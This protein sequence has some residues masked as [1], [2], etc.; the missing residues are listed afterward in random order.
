MNALCSSCRYARVGDNWLTLSANWGL[1]LCMFFGLLQRAGV[2]QSD[3]YSDYNFGLVIVSCEVFVPLLALVMIV[4]EIATYLW[5]RFITKHLQDAMV[6]KALLDVSAMRKLSMLSLRS[7]GVRD[8]E[9]VKRAAKEFYETLNTNGLTTLQSGRTQQDDD[10]MV[11]SDSTDDSD[12][13]DDDD[14]GGEAPSSQTVSSM[15][16]SLTSGPVALVPV[17][18]DEV[19]NL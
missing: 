13:T 12:T 11:F 5:K 15:P 7:M 17:A 16:V 1:W 19:E 10:D 9:Q 14:E 2:N 8:L 4:P 18:E 6:P 3:G